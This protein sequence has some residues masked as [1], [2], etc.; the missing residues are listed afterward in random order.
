M[1]K[2]NVSIVTFILLTANNL[3][4]SAACNLQQPLDQLFSA[5]EY[6]SGKTITP[7][8]DKLAALKE[9][10]PLDL[11]LALEELLQRFLQIK[12]NPDLSFAVLCDTVTIILNNT[13]LKIP[14]QL[15]QNVLE[16]IQDK[17]KCHT[18]ISLRK[19]HKNCNAILLD[20]IN[21]ALTYL[22]DYHDLILTELSS[23]DYETVKLELARYKLVIK[24]RSLR[25]I[26][27][28]FDELIQEIQD[29]Y[30]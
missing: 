2:S 27:T 9:I 6:T 24:R 1:F 20:T 14:D 10:E 21:L 15:K 25:N 13:D 17:R 4:T 19:E 29:I 26:T 5:Y 11:V 12:Q 28:K 22:T 18:I 23:S 30:K 16:L 3:I 7:E 8:T